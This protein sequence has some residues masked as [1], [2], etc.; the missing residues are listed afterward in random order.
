MVQSFSQNGAAQP[1]RRDHS[2]GASSGRVRQVPIIQLPSVS[3]SVSKPANP[4]AH[5]FFYERRQEFVQSSQQL[6]KTS[7]EEKSL[8]LEVS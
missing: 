2:L 1:R 5:T 8:A 4:V 7:H 3:T 6:R